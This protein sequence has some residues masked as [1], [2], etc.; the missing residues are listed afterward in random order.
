MLTCLRVTCLYGVVLG[1]GMLV[2]LAFTGRVDAWLMP[3]VF[4]VVRL[5]F[6]FREARKP[7][8]T[9]EDWWKLAASITPPQDALR[10]VGQQRASYR[11]PRHWTL[12]IA[13]VLGLFGLLVVKPLCDVMT[14]YDFFTIRLPITLPLIGLFVFYAVIY[15]CPFLPPFRY[16]SSVAFIFWLVPIL[17]FPMHLEYL[18]RKEH[19]YWH[20]GV[21]GWRRL[22]AEKVLSLQDK[23]LAALH[24]DWIVNYASTLAD[25]G[26]KPQA[27]LFCQWALELNPRLSEARQLIDRL[28]TGAS[29]E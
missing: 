5:W 23:Q 4:I 22:G 24:A 28:S 2:S 21:P 12:L 20:P 14:A 19:P 10:V 7:V 18:A 16:S 11:P 15:A 25:S 9:D 27:I 3:V 8:M 6:I 13:E 1:F 17:A 29:L 26:N